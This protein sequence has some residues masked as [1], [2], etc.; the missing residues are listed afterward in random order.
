MSQPPVWEPGNPSKGQSQG[1]IPLPPQFVLTSHGPTSPMLA[2]PPHCLSWL[3][4]A[5]C[6]DPAFLVWLASAFSVSTSPVVLVDEQAE[7]PGSQ[8]LQPYLQ[9]K[10]LQV[11]NSPGRSTGARCAHQDA[12]SPTS[13][14]V[15]V[16]PVPVTPVSVAGGVCP[17][18]SHKNG[19]GLLR[20]GS[21]GLVLTAGA[22]ARPPWGSWGLL[23]LYLGSLGL[24]S[25]ICRVGIIRTHAVR[26]ELCSPT[27]H[28]W[29]P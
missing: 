4:A 8:L 28:V 20:R 3:P 23:G 9:C 15:P 22:P 7:P 26:T 25:L 13:A 21:L 18:N 2:S 29:K 1:F 10:A 5:V 16:T 6:L 19:E 14:S 17:F 12:H 27:I 24:S 11:L